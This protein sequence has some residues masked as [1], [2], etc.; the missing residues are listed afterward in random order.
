MPLGM[1][2][3][4]LVTSNWSR[5]GIRDLLSLELDLFDDTVRPRI[6]LE[7]EAIDLP[8]ELALSLGMAFHEL[9]IN[10]VKYGSLSSRSGS[11]RVSWEVDE[12]APAG[13]CTSCGASRAGRR[14]P[15]RSARASAHC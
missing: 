3:T 8:S 15:R 2:H 6:E 7:G 12:A 13:V 4:L 5:I 10:A 9:T 1:T 11:L 14:S